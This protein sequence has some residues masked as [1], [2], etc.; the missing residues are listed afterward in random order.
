M[1]ELQSRNTLQLRK[2]EILLLTEEWAAK[3][4]VYLPFIA[5]AAEPRLL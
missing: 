3:Q 4:R 5:T 2:T 1:C